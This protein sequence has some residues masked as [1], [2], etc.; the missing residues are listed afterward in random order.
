MPL[1]LYD[2]LDAAPEALRATAIETKDG[3]FAVVEAEDVSGLK[4]ALAKERD[5][6]EKAEKAAKLAADQIATNDLREKGLLEAKQEWDAK[7][8]GPIAERAKALETENH[9]LKLVGPVKDAFRSAGII[10]PDDAWV[11][12][13]ADLT[14]SEAGKPM[15]KSDP[16]ADLGKWAESLS[17][18]HPHWFAGS[19]AAGGGAS[20]GGASARGVTTIAAGDPA[21]FLANLDGITKGTVVVR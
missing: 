14:L 17:T 21:A 1:K 4:S 3:K 19:Q 20:G 10:D 5:L 8:L 9:T 7:I 16:T 2:A 6:R 11:R 13:G 15:L 18:A 12:Y